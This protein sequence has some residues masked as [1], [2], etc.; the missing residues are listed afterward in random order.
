[1]SKKLAPII[2]FVYNRL[3]HTQKTIDALEKNELALDSELFIY[4]D[5][6]KK[7]E[8]NEVIEI[9]KYIRTIKNFKKVYII[10]R[11]SNYGLAKNIIEGVTEILKKYGKAIVLE[12]DLI[13]SPY[14]L[15]YMNQSLDRYSNEKKIW[16]INGYMYPLEKTNKVST[17]FWRLPCPW[18]WATWHDRWALFEKNPDR[19]INEFSKKDIYRFNIDGIEGDFWKQVVS[20][21][22]EKINTWA[23]FWYATIFINNGLCLSPTNSYV[24]NGGFDGTGVHCGVEDN[25][26]NVQ[27]LDTKPEIIFC[28]KF[29]ENKAYIKKLKIFLRNKNYPSGT[30]IVEKIPKILVRIINKLSRQALERNILIKID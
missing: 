18:G 13:T 4:S 2:L 24:I 20:N 7:N 11:E 28:E 9:R 27:S 26:Y 15:S 8:D 30:I 1:M 17:F 16:S 29:E 19:L 5:G 10:E 3:S 6:E 12:D 23:V 25:Y 21:K 14:F 22:L